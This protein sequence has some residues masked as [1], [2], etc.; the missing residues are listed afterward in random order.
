M[1]N[2]GV[3]YVMGLRRDD[4]VSPHRSS[5][6]WLRTD[7]RRRYFMAVQNSAYAYPRLSSGS[8]H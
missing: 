1:Q 8:L 7:S 5:L 3:R 2:S 6:G 4:H